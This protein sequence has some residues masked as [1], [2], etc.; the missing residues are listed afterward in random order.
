MVPT[1]KKSLNNR[2]DAYLIVKLDSN[3]FAVAVEQIEGIKEFPGDFQEDLNSEFGLS[4]YSNDDKFLPILN[5]RKYLHHQKSN[6]I[7]SSQS[8]ILLIRNIGEDRDTDTGIIGIVFDAIIE[9]Y[10]GVTSYREKNKENSLFS[11]LKIFLLDSYIKVESKTY[12]IL[13]LEKLIDF[14]LLKNLLKNQL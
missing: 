8:R 2:D 3:E 5:L 10:R 1:N 11:E 12:P 14:S 9:V 7:P 13:N 4:L 6:F